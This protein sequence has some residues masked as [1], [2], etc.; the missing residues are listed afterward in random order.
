MQRP[1]GHLRSLNL[2]VRVADS[3]FARSHGTSRLNGFDRSSAQAFLRS[4][5]IFAGS[6]SRVLSRMADADVQRPISRDAGF[7]A[8]ATAARRAS[9]QQGRQCRHGKHPRP[10]STLVLHGLPPAFDH[11]GWARAWPGGS[12]AGRAGK[13]TSATVTKWKEKE[14]GG[15]WGGPPDGKVE[16]GQCPSDS[17]IALGTCCMNPAEVGAVRSIFGWQARPEVIHDP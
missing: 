3:F 10:P 16:G 6:A 4:R 11:L 1:S 17:S 14:A 2:R 8:V 7:P 15:P 12:I 13:E 5:K 9:A